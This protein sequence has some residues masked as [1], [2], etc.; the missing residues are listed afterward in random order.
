MINS[1]QLLEKDASKRIGSLGC[2]SGDDV[3][4]HP[5][6]SGMDWKRLERKEL[7]PPYK[8]KVVITSLY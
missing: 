3:M 5:F 2:N 4:E 8:P 7:E 6:F 1:I